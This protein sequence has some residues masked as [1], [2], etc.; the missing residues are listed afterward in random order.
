MAQWIRIQ[1]SNISVGH[2]FPMQKEGEKWL[3]V[4]KYDDNLNWRINGQKNW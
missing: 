1:L 4:V 3:N 2:N